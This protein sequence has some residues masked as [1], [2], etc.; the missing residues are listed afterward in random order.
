MMQTQLMQQMAQTIQNNQNNL[1]QQFHQVCDK[2]GEFL[3]GHPPTFTQ[4]PDP[5]YTDDWLHAVERQL[6]IAQCDD[7]EKVLYA[8]G[9]LQG[10]ALDWWESFRNGYLDAN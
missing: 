3:K 1:P 9:Q 10:A 4:S 2:W 7:H 8:S 6:E 5:L